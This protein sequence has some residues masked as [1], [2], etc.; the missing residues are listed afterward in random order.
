[1]PTVPTGLY[2]LSLGN[3]GYSSLDS[4]YKAE[5]ACTSAKHSANDTC[6][7][8][9]GH[10]LTLVTAGEVITAMEF[11][12][13]LV[14]FGAILYLHFKSEQVSHHAGGSRSCEVSDYSILVQKI[15]PDTTA[16]QIITHFTNLYPLDKP[17]WRNR[18]PVYGAQVVDH[19]SNSG[20]SIHMGTW[21]AEA[22]IFRRIG[23]ILRVFKDEEDL[24]QDL[25]E[26]RARM[27]MFKSDTPHKLGPDPK[28][29]E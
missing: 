13:I 3:I 8:V 20:D 5:S 11:L 26:A 17:D 19:Y 12:Q 24:M 10:E 22:T 1:V 18:P 6:I 9:L 25:Y 23:S 7:T 16:M 21:V 14:F 15:P 28:R 4:N 27:K 29:F 2:R